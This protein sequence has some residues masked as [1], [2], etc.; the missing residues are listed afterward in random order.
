MGGK[1][2]AATAE[3]GKSRSNDQ[4][5]LYGTKIPVSRRKFPDIFYVTIGVSVWVRV[6]G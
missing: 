6:P 3:R 1:K 4:T 2:M 5:N